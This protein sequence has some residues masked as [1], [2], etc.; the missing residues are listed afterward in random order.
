MKIYMAM[1]LKAAIEA[2]TSVRVFKDEKIR[3]SDIK[4]MVRLAGLAP[5]VNNSALEVHCHI[6][7]GSSQPDG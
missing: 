5:S 3:L 2:R 4:E 7:Q 1:E 6:E